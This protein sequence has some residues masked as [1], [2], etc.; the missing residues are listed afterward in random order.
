MAT[1]RIIL[2]V[3]HAPIPTV[4][5][6][7]PPSPFTAGMCVWTQHSLAMSAG[8]AA[9]LQ[10]EFGSQ[11]VL[12]PKQHSFSS[13]TFCAEIIWW[14]SFPCTSVFWRR[15]SEMLQHLAVWTRW[16]K[17]LAKKISSALLGFHWKEH[18]GMCNGR[19]RVWLGLPL[20]DSSR[21]H[22]G[23]GQDLLLT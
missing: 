6:H 12:L 22:V 18:Q 15:V 10:E 16:S 21:K 19:V 2:W 7:L 8:F 20:S 1:E 4:S 23:A 17:V 9:N 3:K 13:A 11:N 5:P 14:G